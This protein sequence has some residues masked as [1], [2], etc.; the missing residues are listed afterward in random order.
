MEF[1]SPANYSSPE[2]RT[3]LILL[4][5]RPSALTYNG[6]MVAMFYSSLRTG[7]WKGIG[8]LPSGFDIYNPPNRNWALDQNYEFPDK[9][10]AIDD[11]SIRHSP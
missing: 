5:S 1:F 8:P 10:P 11:S 9:L 3:K 2:D 6:S 7:L 4:T